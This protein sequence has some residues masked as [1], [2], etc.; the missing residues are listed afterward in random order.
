MLEV[1]DHPNELAGIPLLS[2]LQE[3]RLFLSDCCGADVLGGPGHQ[4]HMLVSD[5]TLGEGLTRLWQLVYL[6][7]DG[8]PFSGRAARELAL[9]AQPGDGGECTVSLELGGL[10]EPAQ[11]VGKD[12]LEP[13]DRLA[14]VDQLLSEILVFDVANPG[15]KVVDTRLIRVTGLSPRSA[16]GFMPHRV[17][18][19]CDSCLS[20]LSEI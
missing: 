14:D 13:V 6:A 3:S 17:R 20:Q 4:R 19:R 12:R 11:P 8:H 15:G 9:P 16:S 10:V 7:G 1:L 18:H 2:F 5:F